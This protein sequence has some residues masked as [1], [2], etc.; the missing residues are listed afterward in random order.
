MAKK[1]TLKA[2]RV[3]V[4]HLPYSEEKVFLC[5]APDVVEAAKMAL[6]NPDIKKCMYKEPG[7]T[8]EGKF[9]ECWNLDIQV[10]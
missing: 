4:G 8:P 2:Y 1:K 9:A 3:V 6:D 10:F 5:S 7:E